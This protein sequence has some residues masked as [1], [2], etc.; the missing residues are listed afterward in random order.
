MEQKKYQGK[1]WILSFFLSLFFKINVNT[2]FY[3]KFKLSFKEQIL[4]WTIVY[5]VYKGHLEE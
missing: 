2:T 1:L 4:Q 3:K 5:L